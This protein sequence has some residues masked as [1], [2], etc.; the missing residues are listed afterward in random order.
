MISRFYSH[1]LLLNRYNLNTEGC[2]LS[3]VTSTCFHVCIKYILM[4]DETVAWQVY[5]MVQHSI[6]IYN[7]KLSTQPIYYGWNLSCI[8]RK[9][10]FQFST[11]KQ[12]KGIPRHWS[13][14]SWLAFYHYALMSWSFLLPITVLSNVWL[15]TK[16]INFDS[17]RGS[18]G[19]CCSTGCSKSW[20][21]PG[22]SWNH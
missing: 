12:D 1:Y 2:I 10:I 9:I 6:I 7:T 13:H 8:L 14:W 19:W 17:G 4:S 11:K 16:W 22:C 5:L 15:V 18:S 20:F 3:A 21:N